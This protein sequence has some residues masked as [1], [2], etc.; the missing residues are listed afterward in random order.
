MSQ[1]FFQF[2]K[3][4]KKVE[5]GASSAVGELI[6]TV[7]ALIQKLILLFGPTTNVPY[8]R[9]TSKKVCIGK[10]LCKSIYLVNGGF[11]PEF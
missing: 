11:M 6:L 2:M 1:D 9:R 4:F 8:L 10:R 3:S 7:L 5:A